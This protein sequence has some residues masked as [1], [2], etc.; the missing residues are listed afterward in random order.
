MVGPAHATTISL[1]LAPTR[2]D[3]LLRALRL[4]IDDGARGVADAS[5]GTANLIFL[6]L[7]SLELD[8][9]VVDGERGE[10]Q[11]GRA[12]I[13]SAERQ[14]IV[15]W[16]SPPEDKPFIFMDFSGEGDMEAEIAI[17]GEFRLAAKL[18]P[19]D[20]KEYRMRQMSSIGAHS[21][22]LFAV[23]SSVPMAVLIKS[24]KDVL[25]KWLDT[26]KRT[27]TVNVGPNRKIQVK[28]AD[29]LKD[30]ISMLEGST[31]AKEQDSV[32]RPVKPRK[33]AST[34]TNIITAASSSPNKDS[35][36][37]ARAEKLKSKARPARR[38]PSAQKS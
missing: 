17:F 28:D 15:V 24:V 38:K 21:G 35:P 20:V 8:R 13:R 32:N 11:G 9:L 37:K 27:I 3:A 25:V 19:D 23:A 30:V 31:F 16:S 1:G 36:K 4:L 10:R 34:K 26:T 2:I 22:T 7:K 33:R 29:E 12:M 6:A 14:S 18:P 5:L